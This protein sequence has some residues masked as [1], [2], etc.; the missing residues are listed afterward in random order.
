MQ[1][2]LFILSISL[3]VF[4]LWFTIVSIQEK[5]TRAATIS[6]I[7]AFISPTPY[8]LLALINNSKTNI[9]AFT[10]ILITILVLLL[11]LVPIK[12]RFKLSKETPTKRFDERDTMFSRLEITRKPDLQK[13]YYAKKPNKHNLD[14]NWH[15]KPGLMSEKATF[16]NPLTFKAAD[17]SFYPIE[18]L[19]PFVDG[20]VN[21]QKTA[22]SP[23]KAST[24]ISN[25]SKKLGAVSV[26]ICKTQPY[27]YY[28]V[29]GRGQR[30]N[31]NIENKH[32]Y[33][34]AFTV[35]M[36]KDFLGMGPAGPTLMESA[37]QYMNSGSIAIQ[38]AKFIRDMGYE[39]RA[40]VDGNYE[41]ICPTIARDAGLGE[42]GRMGLLM[43][44]ELGP[45]VRVATITTNLPLKTTNRKSEYS[46]HHFC[47]ICKKCADICPSQAIP[48]SEIQEIEGV[49]KWQINHEKC[50]GYWCTSG[51]DCGRCMS[52]C[53]FSHPNNALHN[54]VRWGI[55]TNVLFRHLALKMD[56]LFY[57]RKPKPKKVPEWMKLQVIV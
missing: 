45:R 16:Y 28:S 51:T 5:E 25:W 9:I 47:T 20:E 21:Q 26:G 15:A 18:Q 37:R 29:G 55:K 52:V 34:I 57:G 3:I 31:I 39:A 1:V 12:G 19:R 36:D 22:L 49:Q 11:L 32:K 40:H 23:E 35:E 53:P 43:T 44:P 6:I 56:D 38:I 7:L 50:F 4:F 14:K 13:K 30:Y 46:Y 17:A 10:L 33:A 54:F 42:I 8:L 48:K 2:I 41:V 27:H 24:F